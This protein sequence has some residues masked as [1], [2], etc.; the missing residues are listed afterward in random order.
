MYLW[1]KAAH[2]ACVLLFV[3]GTLTLLLTGAVLGT[4]RTGEADAA[5]SLRT[6]VRWWDARVTL[7]AMVGAWGFGLWI[8]IS[9]GWF[10]DTWLQ[11]KLL[12]VLVI[13]GV[14]GTLAGR[15]R[16]FDPEVA[17]ARIRPTPLLTALTLGSV[18]GIVVLAIVKPG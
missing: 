10:S 12:L 8:A 2:V 7:P 3:G 16:R 11:I 9:G 5:A 13:S 4:R 14:H 6:T 18:L 1:L 17:E 15:L